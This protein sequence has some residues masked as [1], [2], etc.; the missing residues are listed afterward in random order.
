MTRPDPTTLPPTPK[1][2][3]GARTPEDVELL[4]VLDLVGEEEADRFEGVL[5]A[6]HVVPDGS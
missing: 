2:S 5:A 6:V 4:G 1:Q 3:N